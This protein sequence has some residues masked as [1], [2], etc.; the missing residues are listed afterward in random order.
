MR[1]LPAGLQAALDSGVT[2]L[3]WC[4]RLERSDSVVTGFTDHDR[5]LSFDGVLYRASAL[6][7]TGDVDARSGFAPAT[8]EATGFLTL[9]A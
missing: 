4:W 8:G 7:L 6:S 2:Q 9:T 5:D 1:T 3:C